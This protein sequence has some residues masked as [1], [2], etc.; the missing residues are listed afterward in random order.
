MCLCAWVGLNVCFVSFYKASPRKR[1]SQRGEGQVPGGIW[2]F[3][4]RAGQK[5]RGVSER[6]PWCSG[7][8]QWVALILSEV[9]T[10]DAHSALGFHDVHSQKKSPGNIQRNWHKNTEI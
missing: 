6:A 8:A 3:P 5:K 4:T 7:A 9:L 1:D 10:S 2:E